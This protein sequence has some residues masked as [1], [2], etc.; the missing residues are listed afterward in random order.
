[1]LGQARTVVRGGKPQSRGEWVSINPLLAAKLLEYNAGN[2]RLIASRVELYT[3]QMRDGVWDDRN[4]EAIVIDTDGKLRNGQHRLTAV[5]R[6][7]A[8]VWFKV[9]TGVDPAVADVLDTGKPR[10]AGDTIQMSFDTPDREGQ[11][12]A[13]AARFRLA[14]DR[15]PKSPW[16]DNW[17]KR[18]SN[19]EVR[20]GY[21]VHQV[22]IDAVFPAALGICKTARL[23]G[24]VGMW[25]GVL[26]LLLDA[27][28]AGVPVFAHRVQTGEDLSA[29]DPILHL[30]NRLLVAS[31]AGTLVRSDLQSRMIVY[32]WNAFREG[33]SISKFVVNMGRDFPRPV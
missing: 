6:S 24:G 22:A 10:T 5:I 20:D 32:A 33:R 21:L 29:G 27:H 1:M 25:A 23:R 17:A 18:L 2:R 31:P 14:Y 3:R 4:P 28:R 16:T 11:Q 7:G 30:R 19:A 26:S 8:T 13:T 9:E 12:K 15:A